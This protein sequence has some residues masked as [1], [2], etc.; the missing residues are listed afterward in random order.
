MG[1]CNDID[2]QYNAWLPN[3][4]LNVTRDGYN[5]NKQCNHQLHYNIKLYEQSPF[6]SQDWVGILVDSVSYCILGHQIGAPASSPHPRGV[7]SIVVLQ[8]VVE[9]GV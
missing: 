9:T 1:Q 8:E 3:A 4:Q 6:A 7:A 2:T 5:I